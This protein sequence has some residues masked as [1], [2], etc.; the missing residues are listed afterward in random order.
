MMRASW[1]L[2]ITTTIYYLKMMG[3][4]W[5]LPTTKYNYRKTG[6]IDG[7]HVMATSMYYYTASNQRW[8]RHRTIHFYLMCSLFFRT[9]IVFKLKSWKINDRNYC[10]YEKDYLVCNLP[11][12]SKLHFVQLHVIQTYM[13]IAILQEKGNSFMSGSSHIWSVL[14]GVF[15]FLFSFWYLDG[16][17]SI[18]TD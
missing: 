4:S 14:I 6:L 1:G 8:N 16:A 9:K 2:S 12:K 15:C 13:N 10:P 7:P 11:N 5:G 3:A 17:N 18:K